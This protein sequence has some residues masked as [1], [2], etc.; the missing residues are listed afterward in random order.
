MLLGW[1][2]KYISLTT[3]NGITSIS[4]RLTLNKKILVKN[5][6]DIETSTGDWDNVTC[7]QHL[8]KTTNIHR[9]IIISRQHVGEFL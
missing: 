1:L 7:Y 3:E 9:H 5:D 2:S 4:K 6:F 8:S